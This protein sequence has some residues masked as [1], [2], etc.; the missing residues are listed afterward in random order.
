MCFT[1]HNMTKA[2]WNEKIL[3]D[4]LQNG[5]MLE[6]TMCC[7]FNSEEK[8]VN[9]LDYHGK[10]ENPAKQRVE[11]KLKNGEPVFSSAETKHEILQALEEQDKGFASAKVDENTF[12]IMCTPN[13]FTNQ[14]GKLDFKVSEDEHIQFSA[15]GI[16]AELGSKGMFKMTI[17]KESNPVFVKQ[18]GEA[19]TTIP[20]TPKEAKRR[21][22]E[23]LG[24]DPL[25]ADRT[26]SQGQ[27]K[28]SKG[29]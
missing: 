11:E 8:L 12:H 10:V 13:M 16:I 6:G 2:Q 7:A 9:Y 4:I 23:V 18:V 17:N 26:V 21:M 28:P 22:D 3:P 14:G 27:T 24:A 15:V 20:I 5:G 1:D 25:S 29:R 19:K